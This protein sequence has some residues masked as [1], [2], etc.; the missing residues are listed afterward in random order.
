MESNW[1]GPIGLVVSAA[2][3]SLVWATTAAAGDDSPIEGVCSQTTFEACGGELK[4]TWSIVDGC[5]S[6]MP[7]PSDI[8]K[9]DGARHEFEMQMTGEMVFNE[10]GTSK[11]TGTMKHRMQ[12]DF[13]CSCIPKKHRK[14][15]KKGFDVEDG[16][17]KDVESRENTDTDEGF[18]KVDG[19]TLYLG[20]DKEDL[21]ETDRPYGGPESLE[22][23]VEGKKAWLRSVSDR[24]PDRVMYLERK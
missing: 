20:S 11:M 22:F 8:A 15:A 19:D 2:L 6:R 5:L 1:I 17:C 13:P 3:L 18:Y 23:C 4:G 12:L 7:V 14:R 24:R 10:D 16:R 9:C 21:K